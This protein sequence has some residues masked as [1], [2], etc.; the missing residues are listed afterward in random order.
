MTQTAAEVVEA[1]PHRVRV[2]A[3]IAAAAILA[4]FTAVGTALTGSTGEDGA[5][6]FRPGDQAAMVGLG[7]CGALVALAFTRP[8][9]RADSHGITVRNVFSDTLFPWSVVREIRFDRGHPWASLELV[10][11][12]TVSLLAVQAADKM[13]AVVAIQGLRAL[14]AAAQPVPVEG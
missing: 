11:D 8:R 6:V 4:V 14:H 9:V 10:N 13:H 7:I 3:W 12:D 5:A 1:R 2:V